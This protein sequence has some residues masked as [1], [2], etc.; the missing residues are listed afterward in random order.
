MRHMAYK[1]PVCSSELASIPLR[2]RTCDSIILE[3]PICR[4]TGRQPS[5]T[6]EEEYA[7]PCTKCDGLGIIDDKKLRTLPH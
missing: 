7:E 5:S 4:G 3:C 1:C 6:D 2:C